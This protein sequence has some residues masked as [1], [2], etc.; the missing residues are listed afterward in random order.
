MP[1]L[2]WLTR[3]HDLKLAQNAPYRLL[4]EVPE[5]S[6]GESAT[7]NMLIQGDNLD[8]LKAL[9]PYYAGQVKC[10]YIDPPY[11]T[12]S[13][14][15]HYD[16]NLEHSQWLEM[17]YPRLE[18]LRELLAEE[19]SIWVSIDDNEGH[20]LKVIMDEVFGRRNFVANIVWQKAY[21]SN[22]TAK[23]ISD[24]HDHV[25]L[26]AKNFNQLSLGKLP[27][28]EEQIAKFKN[29][30]SDPRGPWKAE[31]LSAGKFYSAGQFEIIGPTGE[32]F[33]PPKNRYWRCNESQYKE[34]LSQGRITF[35]LSGTGRPMLKK[36]LQEMEDG[37]KPNTWWNHE[38]FGSNKQASI[39][40]KSLFSDAEEIFQTPK[41]EKLIQR[42]LQIS[43]NPGDLVL[44][45]FLGSGTTAAV[46]H[47]LGRRYIGIEMGE[48]AVTHCAPRL[49]KVIEGEQGGISQAVNW[50]GGGGYRFYRLGEAIFDE[51]G[52][53]N[54]A[55]T[56]RTL[57]A[58][59]WFCET[60]TPWVA[61]SPQPS[62][63]GG[64]GALRT[65]ML[66]VHNGTAYYLL[67]NGILGDKRLDGGNV[68]TGK[69]LEILPSHNGPKVIYGETSRL[70]NERLRRENITFRQIPYDIK[71]R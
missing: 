5:L 69:L 11:N 42:I 25:L 39:D 55:I 3:E 12:R 14:F 20:Y 56:F 63:T 45:S 52:R 18:L 44:D 51:Y 43:T 24:T 67:F 61:P 34:W 8:A 1:V 27:R 54:R 58:H 26:Y 33:L 65:P 38:E 37:L 15:E 70:S 60:R 10:I 6:S 49:K 16:D 62:L 41:P 28:T 66:G 59:V 46:A 35:G 2:T 50:Q 36:Y 22:Q 9:L 29:P 68:L 30:D 53:I 19:G 17:I 64:V 13:A 23:H 7:E 31:N 32:R 47:K 4:E 48:H 57:A 71:A 40:L 21:T